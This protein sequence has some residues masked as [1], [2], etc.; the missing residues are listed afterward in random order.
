MVSGFIAMI[1]E[2]HAG[3]YVLFGM[4]LLYLI[5]FMVEDI[6]KDKEQAHK[7]QAHKDMSKSFENWYKFGYKNGYKDCD[8]KKP[9][10]NEL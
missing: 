3:A 6:K 9:F 4:V 8:N 5:M 10:D 2:N 7:E 1:I